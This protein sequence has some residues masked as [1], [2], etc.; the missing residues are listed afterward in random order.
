MR[1]AVRLI[2]TIP[3]FLILLG[4]EAIARLEFRL[5]HGY[6][7]DESFVYVPD[8]ELIFVNNPKSHVYSHRRSRRYGPFF[9]SP[10][11]D[12]ERQRILVLGGSTS[13]ALP[14]GSDW[15]AVFERLATEDQPIAVV[16]MGHDGYGTGQIRWLYRH[17]REE[18]KPRGIIVFEG[19]NYR[20]VLT[21]R[22]GYRPV[23]ACSSFD[24][25]VQ[26]VSASLINHSS[27]YSRVFHV[28]SRL[29]EPECRK[30]EPYGEMREWFEEFHEVIK[31]MQQRDEVFLVLFPGLVMRDDIRPLVAE[32]FPC[33]AKH[34]DVHRAE[35]Q[36]RIVA[37]K[38][39]AHLLGVPILDARPAYAMLTPHQ[40]IQHFFDR[41]HQTAEGNRLLGETLYRE[42][43]A[44]S[45]RVSV[46][47]K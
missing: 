9:I 39:I 31:E 42:F 23:N 15:P 43:R 21:S 44:W 22:L 47:A 13:K 2:A 3:V 11:R 41:A 12:D 17:Y 19:W 32:R 46:P 30:P 29:A 4:A 5:R 20:G 18:I 24:S 35:Y 7:F 1:L 37:I 14:D 40:H 25:R 8:R 26:C 16:N 34:F 45:R 10:P 33:I 36:A 28:F 27:A 38:R 6:S